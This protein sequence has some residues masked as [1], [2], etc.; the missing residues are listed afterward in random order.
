M[1]PRWE[2]EEEEW[3]RMKMS[4]STCVGEEK[5]ETIYLFDVCGRKGKVACTLIYSIFKKYRWKEKEAK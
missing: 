1:P 2:E 5:D 4:R 3:G